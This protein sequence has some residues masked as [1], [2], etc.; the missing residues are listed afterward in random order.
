MDDL[1]VLD[2]GL[3]DPAVEVEHMRRR[4][5]VPHWRLV[6]KFY[7]IVQPSILVSDQQAVTFLQTI[8]TKTSSKIHKEL[9]YMILHTVHVLH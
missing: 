1:E 5:F 3:C 7:Q 4:I 6:V 2:G 8:D 9:Q